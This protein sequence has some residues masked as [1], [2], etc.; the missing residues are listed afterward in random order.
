MNSIKHCSCFVMHLVPC[1][2][3]YL[4]NFF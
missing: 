2:C 1:L 4:A 3:R